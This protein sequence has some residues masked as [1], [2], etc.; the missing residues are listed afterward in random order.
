VDSHLV[1]NRRVV[2]SRAII[3]NEINGFIFTM[4]D[5]RP[6]TNEFRSVPFLQAEPQ[7]MRFVTSYSLDDGWRGR[8][9]IAVLQ[10]I[11]GEDKHGVRLI[12]NE[13]PYTGGSQAGQTITSIEQDPGSRFAIVH[14]T[15]IPP[16]PQSFVL[17]DRL[18]YCRFLYLQPLPDAPFQTWRSDWVLPGQLPLGIRIEMA[19]LDTAGS[20]LH[21][22]TVTAPLHPVRTPGVVYADQL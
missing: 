11:P 21:V 8:P 6:G 4:A 7:S 1:M 20:T 13:M 22:T 15:P 12:V 9:Q 5:Y 2:N 17:A 10:V 18:A 16:G 3:E 19:P 14:F